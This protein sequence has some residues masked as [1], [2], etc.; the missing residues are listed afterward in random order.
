MS[1]QPSALSYKEMVQSALFRL[2]VY[3]KDLIAEEERH[4]EGRGREEE[5]RGREGR[6]RRVYKQE[7]EKRRASMG[8]SKGQG[9]KGTDGRVRDRE[10]EW[11]AGLT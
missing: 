10:S 11:Y 9:K 7:G 2:L 3:V 4:A 6:G 1:L 5:K 8:K